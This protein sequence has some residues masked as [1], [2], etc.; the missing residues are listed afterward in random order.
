MGP[1]KAWRACVPPGVCDLSALGAVASKIV[2]D[3]RSGIVFT[4]VVLPGE[5]VTLVVERAR[6]EDGDGIYLG[7]ATDV[8]PVGT[9]AAQALHVFDGRLY[10]FDNALHTA[11]IGPTKVVS[12]VHHSLAA[13][14]RRTQGFSAAQ[15]RQFGCLSA[16]KDPASES[17][18]ESTA[19]EASAVGMVVGIRVAARGDGGRS[20]V[21]SF[22]IDEGPWVESGLALS[23]D[24]SVYARLELA[25]DAVRLVDPSA[26]AAMHTHIHTDTHA[27]AHAYAHV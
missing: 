24:V 7:G 26:T 1:P 6:F 19:R 11:V 12:D 27:C 14:S 18:S 25:G 2:D 4:R 16:N 3:R 21:L 5:E 23:G 13:V 8:T 10:A 17:T 20:S 22:R 9:G 15:L